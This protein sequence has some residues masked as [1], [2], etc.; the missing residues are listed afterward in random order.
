MKNLTTNG[1]AK[2]K[3]LVL[4]ATGTGIVAEMTANIAVFASPS[5]ALAAVTDA[6]EDLGESIANADKGDHVMIAIR[7]DKQA[8]VVDLLQ[9]LGTYVNLI[10]NGSRTTALLSGFE[11]RKESEPRVLQPI[12]YAPRT[13]R[14][15]TA[16]SV[17]ASIKM[18]SAARNGV[19]WYITH[20]ATKPLSTWTKIDNEGAKIT[21]TDLVPG[22]EYYICAELLGARRQRQMSPKAT[23][24]A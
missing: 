24:I 15:L 2:F 10:A 9:Q 19:I 23:V 20:D 18:Q 12:A 21:F 4:V 8:V 5:P 16:G 22:T 3:P 1:F 17:A 11:L 14:S 6:L 7:D 13:N